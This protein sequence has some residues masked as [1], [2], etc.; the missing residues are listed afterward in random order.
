MF[1]FASIPARRWTLSAVMASLTLAACG[2][3]GDDPAAP[4]VRDTAMAVT[5]VVSTDVVGRMDPRLAFANQGW[6]AQCDGVVKAIKYIPEPGVTGAAL[7]DGSTLK[8]GQWDSPDADGSA[9][10]AFRANQ[11]N[12]LT[13]GS[14][15]CEGIF[16]DNAARFPV[17]QTTWF[18]FRMWIDNWSTSNTGD[19]QLVT[20]LWPGDSTA[21]LNPL[22][23]IYVANTTMTGIVRYDLNATPSKDTDVEK[24][25]FQIKGGG[26]YGRWVN[27]V[28]QTVISRDLADGPSMKL[29]MDGTLIGNYQGPLGFNLSTLPALKVGV[30]KYNS[31]SW[32]MAKPTRQV[33][34]KNA[35]VVRDPSKLYTMGDIQAELLR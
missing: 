32:D 14:R 20:Q 21:G 4:A 25:L 10:L 12:L 31:S 11:R 26:F 28:A 13:S 24:Q 5:G 19:Q 29:W 18:A 35:I 15:R 16:H 23:A 34:L 30:Y 6:Q 1:D 9:V 3:G 17:G 33:F 7:E 2:G 8:L 22:F 27:V